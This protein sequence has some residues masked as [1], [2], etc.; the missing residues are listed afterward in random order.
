M[1]HLVG[2]GCPIALAGAE[3]GARSTE[4]APDWG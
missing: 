4:L 2:S 1:G 3:H